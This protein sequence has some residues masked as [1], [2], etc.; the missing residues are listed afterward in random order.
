MRNLE[1]GNPAFLVFFRGAVPDALPVPVFRCDVCIE[2]FVSDP[3]RIEVKKISAA[4]VIMRVEQDR[5]RVVAKRKI[6]LAQDLGNDI[7]RIAVPETPGDIDRVLIVE[8]QKSR[9]L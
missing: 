3:V 5:Y 7:V 1:F 4:A 9:W 8:N 2:S 6:S